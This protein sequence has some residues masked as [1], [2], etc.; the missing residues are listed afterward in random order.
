MSSGQQKESQRKERSPWPSDSPTSRLILQ[1]G[2]DPQSL[3]KL[4]SS[5]ALNQQ[6]ELLV[7]AGA[8]QWADHN[9]ASCLAPEFF[10]GITTVISHILTTEF[11]NNYVRAPEKHFYA[12][13]HNAAVDQTS[14]LAIYPPGPFVFPRNEP[15]HTDVA[16]LGIRSSGPECRRR[17]VFAIRSHRNQVGIPTRERLSET[18][19]HVSAN[20]P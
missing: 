4:I 8:E 15:N 9:P 17:S 6:V 11:L 10:Y 3:Q 16:S 5:H 2:S 18:S 13:Q 12:L 7:P 1:N 14:T 20:V 19:E